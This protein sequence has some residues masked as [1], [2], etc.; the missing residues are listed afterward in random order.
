[1]AVAIWIA[2][3]VVLLVLVVALAAWHRRRTLGAQRPAYLNWG[4][5]VLGLTGVLVFWN[6]FAAEESR[7]MIS[8]L[9]NLAFFAGIIWLIYAGVHGADRF[10]VNLS[11]AFFAIALLSRY[12]DTFWTLMG[13]SYFFMVGGVL[14]LAGGYLLERQRRRLTRGMGGGERP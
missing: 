10:T 14:L 7:G 8:I 3:S 6:L 11:F 2:V 9:F 13:R 12:L 4:W 5:A 1:V